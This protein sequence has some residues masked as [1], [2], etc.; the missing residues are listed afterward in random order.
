MEAGIS[1]E[2]IQEDFGEIGDL[3]TLI[4]TE[5]GCSARPGQPQFGFLALEHFGTSTATHVK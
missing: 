4:L 5:I 1:V 3:E 2:E